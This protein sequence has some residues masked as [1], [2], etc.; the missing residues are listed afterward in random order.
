MVGHLFITARL[1]CPKDSLQC[2][3]QPGTSTNKS[4]AIYTVTMT[5][6]MEQAISYTHYQMLA[7]TVPGT[8]LFVITFIAT[9]IIS[10][11]IHYTIVKRLCKCCF[12]KSCINFLKKCPK[13]SVVRNGFKDV[14][15]RMSNFLLFEFEVQE[16]NKE[17]GEDGQLEGRTAQDTDPD[18]NDQQDES[19]VSEAN[20]GQEYEL[21]LVQE[22]QE[23]TQIEQSTSQ[24][25]KKQLLYFL[26]GV[27][28]HYRVIQ[29]LFV[30]SL[31]V[32]GMSFVLF[33]NTFIAEEMYGCDSDYDC[34][35]M[36]TSDKHYN[37]CELI[38]NCTEFK[39]N[40]FAVAICYRLVFKFSEGIG[41]SGGFLF[42]MQVMVNVLIYVTLRVRKINCNNE[43]RRITVVTLLS[44]TMFTL[45]LVATL[46]APVVI[47]ILEPKV[48]ETIR[49]P[50]R[51]LQFWTYIYMSF[52]LLFVVP[53]VA[54]GTKH[55]NTNK[56]T[57]SKA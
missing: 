44:L 36:H 1:P 29:F 37:Q 55:S 23:Y 20:D 52:I 53:F 3:F 32:I 43:S 16:G 48:N 2:I 51:L 12:T 35:V 50:Q 49:T 15:I 22:Y 17:S 25:R 8:L 45:Q 5:K 19:V 10:S 14:M 18:D 39:D 13:C 27:Q 57:I 26:Y 38:T 33:W 21:K 56:Q 34:F 42:A 31:G 28:V 6:E 47:F 46:I 54:I 4:L 11:M 41:D 7:Y 24:K 40:K 9:V 30:V